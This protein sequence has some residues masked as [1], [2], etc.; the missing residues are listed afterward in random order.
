MTKGFVLNSIMLYNIFNY[1]KKHQIDFTGGRPGNVF[2]FDVKNGGGKTSLFLSIK[3]GFYGFD[4]GIS[5]VKDGV[6]LHA[7]DFMNQDEQEEGT[8]RVV[9]DFDYD[10]DHM[11]LRRSCPDYHN[12]NTELTLT[13]NGFMEHGKE[14]K[15]HVMKI[16]PP[17]YGD[18]FMFDGETLQKIASQQGDKNKT[19]NVM[20]LLGLNQL[21]DLK[22]NLQIIQKSISSEFT[23]GKSVNSTLE[24]LTNELVRLQEKEDRVGKKLENMK[25]RASELKSKISTLEEKRRLY[26]NIESTIDEDNKKKRELRTTEQEQE[27]LQN[28]IREY[29]KDAFMLFME[30]DIRLLVQKYENELDKLRRE[31]KNDRRVN[32]EFTH[33]QSN[34]VKEH[35]DRCPVCN[36]L[37]SEEA[38]QCL[39]ELIDQ[40]KDKGELFKRHRDEVNRYTQYLDL[41]KSQLSRIP[42]DLNKKCDDLFAASEKINQLNTRIA[43]LNTILADSDIEAVKEL[44]KELTNLYSDQASL[45]KDIFNE[46]NVYQTTVGKLNQTRKKISGSD[47]L[48]NQQKVLSA[49]ML[50]LDRLIKGLDAAIIKVSNDKRADILSE[51]NRVFMSIT[52]K[53]DVYCGLAY[54]ESN[55]FSMHIVRNDGRKTVL[56]SSGENHVLA[57]SFLISLSLNTERLTPMM[58][59][60]PLSRLDDVHK[61]NIGR[62]LASLDNQVI[63]LAQPGELDE[64]TKNMLM[65]SVSKMYSA[66]PTSDNTACI[67]EVII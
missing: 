55:S 5:Y 47:H 27:S 41:L 38:M 37:L 4:A 53:Q 43:E 24:N 29:S 17:D 49:R 16:L 13:I 57:I 10:G 1:R 2:L 12:D 23:Q 60:T 61:P 31:S 22:N 8:F 35:M 52:N 26:S 65:P 36:S 34:I 63:F 56:P 18:F 45:N 59:D 33:I 15:D 9:I 67:K 14:A 19:N 30:S 32:N 54:D 64:N 6:T 11:Q 42:K 62:T 28:Y 21:K 40:S 3:W 39:C 51:A 66:E 44:S 48:S 50:R 46:N 20:K 25:N 58:M 7:K